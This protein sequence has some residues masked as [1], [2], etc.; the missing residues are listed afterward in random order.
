M[1]GPRRPVLLFSG[2]PHG[3]QSPRGLLSSDLPP[4]FVPGFCCGDGRRVDCLDFPV[5]LAFCPP[6]HS[7]HTPK[8]PLFQ[9][10]GLPHSHLGF[11]PF[12]KSKSLYC[13]AVS[14]ITKRPT[15]SQA[16]GLSNRSI[17]SDVSRWERMFND[18]CHNQRRSTNAIFSCIL[19]RISTAIPS[20]RTLSINSSNPCSNDPPWSPGGR[21][22][23]RMRTP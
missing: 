9:I 11:S 6:S 14:L 13:C 20:A 15:C 18:P 22:T 8:R 4:V 1:N 10:I 12:A 23:I 16:A 5:A 2:L 17:L 7:N 19:A 21:M 3:G